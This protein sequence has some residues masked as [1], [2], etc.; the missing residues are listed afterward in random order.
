MKVSE[1][2]NIAIS[3]VVM[4]ALVATLFAAIPSQVRAES[5]AGSGMN[6]GILRGIVRDVE[7]SPIPDATVAIFR[8][9][10]SKLLQQVRSNKEG[11]YLLR[12]IPGT[13]S[14]LAVAQGFNPVRLPEVAIGRSGPLDHGFR[15]ERAGS[16]NTLPERRSDRNNPKWVRRAA[17]ISRTVYQNREGDPLETASTAERHEPGQRSRPGQ[18]VAETYI[19]SS[20]QGVFSGINYATRVDVNNKTD[21]IIAAQTGVGRG[22]PQR[23]EAYISH[24]AS[25]NHTLRLNTS[26]G[27]L[28]TIRSDGNESGLGQVTFQATDEWRVREGV[29]LVLG[30]DVSK[31]VGAGSDVFVAPRLG[32]QLDAGPKTRFRAAFTPGTDDRTWGREIELEG[33]QI[34]FREPVA[35]NDVVVEEGRPRLNRSQRFEFGLERVLDNRSS[36]EAN[37]FFD[38][39]LNR[40]VGIQTFAFD[41]SASPALSEFTGNQA[42]DATGIRVVYSRR[43]SGRMTASGGYSFGTGQS[44]SAEGVTNPGELFKSDV[45][46]T[47]YGQFDADLGTGTTVRTVFRLSPQATVFA[48]D[49]FRGRLAIYDPSLSI[50]VTQSLPTMGLPFQAE[51]VV[52]ARNLLDFHAGAISE[53]GSLRLN[54]QRRTLRGGIL[55]RF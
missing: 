54:G 23:L 32:F 18:S 9:G 7:G 45:F 53:A 44:L 37:V 20:D 30:A 49:P 14:V 21:L 27:L 47:L 43:I 25:P 29:I 39:T 4:T 2:I 17:T 11:R 6:I 13:Y 12:M 22:A 34:M 46:H 31:F 36:I 41:G 51:A 48:I 1:N 24:L 52:D 8:V 19:A 42:G 33:A 5:G 15:L 40:G 50:L 35:V 28:G 3:S 55:V 26:V 38:T 10:T 16:G